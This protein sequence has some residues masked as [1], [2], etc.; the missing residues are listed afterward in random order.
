MRSHTTPD[1]PD[2]ED[3]NRDTLNRRFLQRTGNCGI[4]QRL[5]D[6]SGLLNRYAALQAAEMDSLSNVHGGH[7]GYIQY[8]LRPTIQRSCHAASIKRARQDDCQ[9]APQTFAPGPE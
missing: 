7:V 6:L 5:Q 4:S 8:P 2:P 9:P 1:G 3:G